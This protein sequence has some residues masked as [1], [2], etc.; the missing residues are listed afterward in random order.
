MLFIHPV[1]LVL[2]ETV[3]LIPA[4]PQCHALTFNIRISKHC[5]RKMFFFHQSWFSEQCRPK[6]GSKIKHGC[7]FLSFTSL[8][9]AALHYSAYFSAPSP[10]GVF[11]IVSTLSASHLLLLLCFFLSVLKDIF[12]SC[13]VDYSFKVPC[14]IAVMALQH[15]SKIASNLELLITAKGC[16]IRTVLDLFE[17]WSVWFDRRLR[18]VPG[19]L[20]C[21]V[22]RVC[23]W[24]RL[25]SRAQAQALL[26][27]GYCLRPSH[28]SQLLRQ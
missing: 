20:C 5:N 28:C 23:G 8:F 3:K 14:Y 1:G 24:I 25:P 7:P 12:G 19:V 22:L 16:W 6:Y 13:H 21:V 15:M 26:I 10:C 17:H 2:L 27:F 4:E 18:P 11:L 9:S